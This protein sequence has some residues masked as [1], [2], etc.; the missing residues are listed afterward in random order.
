M[1]GKTLTKKKRETGRKDDD[2]DD[3]DDDRRLQLRKAM[4]SRRQL[5]QSL[6][7]AL[8]A[9]PRLSPRERA[10]IS[11]LLHASLPDFQ[12]FLQHT[13]SANPSERE[14]EIE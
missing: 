8:L 14:R 6:E 3:D 7:G 10:E 5:L 11:H 13:V 4:V 12:S 2:D 9:G 1:E